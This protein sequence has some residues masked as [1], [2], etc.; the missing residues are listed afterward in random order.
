[1]LSAGLLQ[2]AQTIACGLSRFSTSSVPYPKRIKTVFKF[3]NF[4]NVELQLD[5]C[6]LA[7]S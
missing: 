6:W 4:V 5:I 7:A 3:Q 2:V 1:L